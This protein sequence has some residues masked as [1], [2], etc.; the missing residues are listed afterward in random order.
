M[1]K[2]MNIGMIIYSQ[3]GNTHSVAIKLEEKLAA[4]GHSVDMERLKVVGEYRPGTSDV[5]FETLPNVGQY[6]ALVFG[7]PV[8][9]FSLSPVMK[10]YLTQIPSLQDKKVACLVTQF[11]PFRWL[12]GNRAVRQMKRICESKGAAVCG[13][14]IVNWSRSRRDQQIAEVTDRLSRLF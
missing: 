1:R 11:F 4:A 2:K 10:S 3:T 7:A 9:A 13:S 8:E 6:D 12:G 14:G 5:R